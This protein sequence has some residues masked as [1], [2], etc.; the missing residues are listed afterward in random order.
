MFYLIRHGE[1]NYM[2]RNSKIYQG[3]GV[4]LSPLSESGIKQIKETAKDPRLKNADIILSSPYTRALQTAAILSKELGID[5]VVESDLHEWLANKN[6]I[7]DKD[8][9]AEQS[10]KE[11][12]DCQGEYLDGVERVWEDN[13]IMR[14][15][16]LSVLG[17]YGDD[18]DV[19]VAC[20][21]M[22]IQAVTEKHYPDYGEI[23]EFELS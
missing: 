23:M 22:I 11:F 20:H 3:F 4:N 8:S 13:M 21:G 10:Y 9:K 2:E 1:T 16:V 19:I 18:R 7:Y 6:Y 12:I 17:K 14:R 5:I 15:R